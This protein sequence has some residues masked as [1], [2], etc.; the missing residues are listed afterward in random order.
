M[1]RS[2][3]I[4]LVIATALSTAFM[5]SS[6]HA[7]A[8]P[9]G[10]AVITTTSKFTFY[11]AVVLTSSSHCASVQDGW[12]FVSVYHP[13]VAGNAQHN[14]VGMTLTTEVQGEGFRLNNAVLT[15]TFKSVQSISYANGIEVLPNAQ[16]RII[17]QTPATLTATTPFLKLRGEIKRPFNDAGSG[18]ACIVGF[19]ASYF[20]GAG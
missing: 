8:E 6:N 14:F 1:T 9:I 18:G 5:V 16:I 17:S 4:S 10:P 2:R 13:R 11:G 15:S 7:S 3:R 19:D 20:R 12:Q